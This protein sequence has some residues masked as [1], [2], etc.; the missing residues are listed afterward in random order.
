VE[1]RRKPHPERVC[2]VP[3]LEEDRMARF[4]PA[5]TGGSRER[6][7]PEATRRASGSQ[8]VEMVQFRWRGVG[9]VEKPSP[10]DQKVV[11]TVQTWSIGGYLFDEMNTTLLSFA[12]IEA[13]PPRLSESS[14]LDARPRLF[15]RGNRCGSVCSNQ[16]D[17]IF[18]ASAGFL[19]GIF[20]PSSRSLPLPA[21]IVPAVQEFSPAMSLGF[22]CPCTITE[23]EGY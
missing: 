8:G 4:A 10:S 15:P 16:R 14:G 11:C 5:Q 23:I 9:V 19:T 20:W 3:G 7:I 12:P 18:A 22:R 2:A 17:T 13:A 6:A 1:N 21:D